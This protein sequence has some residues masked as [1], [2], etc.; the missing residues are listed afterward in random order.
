MGQLDPCRGVS[1]C[2]LRD[3][4][5]QDKTQGRC[6]DGRGLRD[7]KDVTSVVPDPL[8]WQPASKLPYISA[9]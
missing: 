5:H 3:G 8:P 7:V 1:V 6:R 4:H 2:A 9:E